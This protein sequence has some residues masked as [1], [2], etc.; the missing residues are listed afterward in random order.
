MKDVDKERGFKEILNSPVFRNF[1]V[2]KDGNT[3]GIIVY[4][5]KET[6]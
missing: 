5:K 2:S 1:V 3:S 4:I 6:F